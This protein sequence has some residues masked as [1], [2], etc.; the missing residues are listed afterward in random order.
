M[1][2]LSV[3]GV[4]HGTGGRT[5]LLIDGM[6]RES[7]TGSAPNIWDL[8]ISGT[9]TNCVRINAVTLLLDNPASTSYFSFPV[10]WT[11]NEVTW[12]TSQI[13]QSGETILYHSLGAVNISTTLIG[14]AISDAIR[15]VGGLNTSSQINTYAEFCPNKT[16]PH[17][18]GE[19]R[20][21]AHSTPGGTSVRYT[22]PS[23][24]DWGSAYTVT[25]YGSAI[26][27][28]IAGK[29]YSQT[30]V[31]IFKGTTQM[32]ESAEINF[33]TDFGTYVT[34]TAN[35]T[36]DVTTSETWYVK[37]LHYYGGAW[38]VGSSVSFSISFSGQPFAYARTS[39]VRIADTM[40]LDFTHNTV[41]EG[42]DIRL[43]VNGANGGYN[44][45]ICDASPTT[46]EYVG[47]GPLSN[48]AGWKLEVYYNLQWVQLD[49]GT[50]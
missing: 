1:A 14:N 3:N 10:H 46:I 31:A 22:A 32:A 34:Y 50:R 45:M 37:T 24:V 7:I 33:N 6:F 29:P 41:L 40:T 13:G 11:Q 15:T 16:A 26:F 5:K 36:Y 17:G 21:Y 27:K 28:E 35:N 8:P 39:I 48:P 9:Y 20:W 25:G 49:A 38:V 43:T 18:L 2:S 30:K 47:P 23:T 19:F 12:Y 44:Q 42:Y 4:I